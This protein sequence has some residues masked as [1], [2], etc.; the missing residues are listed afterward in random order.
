MKRDWRLKSR[1]F[2]PT[3]DYRRQRH[4]DQ[5]TSKDLSRR[6]EP[7]HWIKKDSIRHLVS[8][9]TQPC[10]IH[11]PYSLFRDPLKVLCDESRMMRET[12]RLSFP[13]RVDM[14]GTTS[15]DP[16]QL[17]PPLFTCSSVDGSTLSQDR[18]TWTKG[19]VGTFVI[20]Q[21]FTWK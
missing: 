15:W 21:I 7:W 4:A 6:I 17:L 3:T 16:P 13:N 20:T 5:Y 9:T 14:K 19:T 2:R 11:V 12:I 8:P 18:Y 1:Q 10:P